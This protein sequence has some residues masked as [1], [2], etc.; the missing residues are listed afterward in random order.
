MPHE[1]RHDDHAGLT[2]N[3]TEEER[4]TF[5]ERSRINATQGFKGTLGHL[6]HIWAAHRRKATL[7]AR[8]KQKIGWVANRVA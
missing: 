7:N 1:R 6:M 8:E 5:Q 3:A 2:I 4:Q